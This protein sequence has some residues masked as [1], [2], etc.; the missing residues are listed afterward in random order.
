MSE[1]RTGRARHGDRLWL[2]INLEI[3]LRTFI[4]GEGPADVIRPILRPCDCCGSRWAGYGPPPRAG[5]F[6]VCRRCRICRRAIRSHCSRLMGLT[7]IR[8]DWR[9]AFR[10]VDACCPCRLPRRSPGRLRSFAHWRDRGCRAIQSISGSGGCRR[11]ANRS[12]GCSRRSR[13]TFAWPTSWLPL[14][15]FHGRYQ[16]PVVLFEHNV[17]Y[18]IWQRLATLERRVARRTL[19][20]IEWRKLRR[21]EAAACAAAD[22]TIA[23]SERTERHSRLSRGARGSRQSPLASTPRTSRPADAARSPAGCVFTGSMDWFPNKTPCSASAK[24]SCRAFAPG[25]PRS[26]S[27]SSAAILVRPSPRSRGW[28]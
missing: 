18:L 17:E 6:V 13:S 10:T 5:G 11:C 21:S 4:D 23:V 2:L 20:E 27:A 3:W 8:R 28:G 12:T 19:L 9:V 16:V 25:S 26:P 14:R 22:L 15:T 1:H 24:R 7:T